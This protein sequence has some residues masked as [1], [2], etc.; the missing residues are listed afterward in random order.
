MASWCARWA[1]ARQ[2]SNAPIRARGSPGRCRRCSRSRLPEWA[3][4]LERGPGALE[5]SDEHA[6]AHRERMPGM[7]GS[8]REVSGA[9]ARR[10]LGKQ[11]P[12][13]RDV[14]QVAQNVLERRESLDVGPRGR[15][16]ERRDEEI[17]RI[18]QPLHADAQA[19]AALGIAPVDVLR[20]FERPAMKA[21]QRGRCERAELALCIF[22]VTFPRTRVDPAQRSQEEGLKLWRC[23][24]EARAAPRRGAFDARAC[25]KRSD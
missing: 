13:D 5:R 3:A 2:R 8:G 17:A 20:L 7:P 25:K 19:M 16:G 6:L 21:L 22:P 15:A 11:A 4:L 23:G 1:T 24:R 10:D 12:R 14:V 18:A 9:A